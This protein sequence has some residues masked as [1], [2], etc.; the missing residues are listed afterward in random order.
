MKDEIANCKKKSAIPIYEK[1]RV[2][3]STL[4]KEAVKSLEGVVVNHTCVMSTFEGN[5]ALLYR[6]I[7][8]GLSLPTIQFESVFDMMDY[9]KTVDRKF[10]LILD[11]YPYLMQTRM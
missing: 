7:I 9:L 4:I 10:F 11:E 3:K 1:R 2:G 5:L 6:S 8:E